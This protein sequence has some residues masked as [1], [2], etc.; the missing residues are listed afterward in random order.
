MFFRS[1]KRHKIQPGVS[2]PSTPSGDAVGNLQSRQWQEWRTS[3][4]KA[5][6]AWNEWLAANSRERAEYYRRY[7][8]AL[9]AEEL[10]ATELERTAN[11]DVIAQR[12]S[13]HPVP[14][15]HGGGNPR[16]EV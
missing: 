12:T 8:S 13:D 11:L 3:A 10:A 16:R 1:K 4:Q 14:A 5:R 15:A 2:H 7:V 6:R 9:A